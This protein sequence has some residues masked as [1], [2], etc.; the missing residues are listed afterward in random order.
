MDPLLRRCQQLESLHALAIELLR[1]DDYDEMLDTVVRHS[2]S[3]LGADRGFLVL[4][5][6]ERW[7]FK[8]VRNW[9]RD[10]IQPGREPLSRSIVAEILQSGQPIVIPDA[11]SDPRFGE[12]QSVRELQIRSVL[13]APVEVE[14][15]VAGALYLESQSVERPFGPEEL[16]LFTRIVELASRALASCMHRIV[17]EQRAALLEKDFLARY[18]FQGIVTRDPGFVRVLETVAQVAS[19]DLPVLVQGPSGSGKELIIR[20]IHINSPRSKRPFLTVNCSAISPQLLESELFGHVR[21]AFTGAVSDKVGL[22][23]AAHTGSVFLDEIGELPKELQAKLLR[24]LQFGE[25]QPV[26]SP[27]TQIVDVRF[28]AATNRD[29]KHEVRQGRFREDLLYRL[30]AVTIELPPLK[31][32]PADILPLFYHFL[33]RAAAKAGLPIPEVSPLVERRLQEW[34]WPGNVR[35]LENEAKRLLALT[36]PGLPLTADRLSPALS[37]RSAK[38]PASATSLAEREKELIELQLRLTAGNRTQTAQNLGISR[39]GLRK[40][41]KRYGLA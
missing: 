7:D 21:G 32:R 5:H 24:T 10:D 36:H 1:L 33:G 13:A 19:S 11:L 8:V 12:L 23:P 27:R 9:S 6:Q 2:L 41:M 40:K 30:N 25:V 35:E 3:S 15:K 28:L 4:Q 14:G 26:G 34:H 16:E 39:E 29:L 31:N 20:A 37:K 17:L 38:A 22:L 18:D